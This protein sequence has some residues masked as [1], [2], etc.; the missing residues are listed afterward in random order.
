MIAYVLNLL[1]IF[2]LLRFICRVCL[3]LKEKCVYIQPFN[4]VVVVKFN[5]NL[6]CC[7]VFVYIMH[8]IIMHLFD[9]IAQEPTVIMM[10][11]FRPIIVLCDY[12]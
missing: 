4:K 7:V 11:V 12:L 10:G 1:R 6:R 5:G 8:P 3:Q 9:A 2:F